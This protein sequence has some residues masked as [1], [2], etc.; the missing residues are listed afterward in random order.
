MEKVA[1]QLPRLLRSLLLGEVAGAGDEAMFHM[2]NAR[3]PQPGNV[4][5][6]VT[7]LPLA[8]DIQQR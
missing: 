4:S 6:N 5:L 2:G 8:P 7:H 3:G 1:D